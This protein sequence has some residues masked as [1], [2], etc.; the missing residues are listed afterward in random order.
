MRHSSRHSESGLDSSAHGSRL[1]AHGSPGFTLVGV[2]VA[3]AI[4]TI[5]VAAI[6]PS[7]YAISQREK[8]TE[9]IFRG[10]QYARAIVLFQRKFGRLPN[11]INEL[12]KS[13]PHTLRKRYKEPMCD[14][15]QWHL[16]IAGTPDASPPGAIPGLQGTP[17]P[18]RTPGSGNQ[19]PS[20]YT[21]LFS[22]TPPPGAGGAAPTP[23]FPS[24]F[25]TPGDQVVGPIVGVRSNVHKRG[26]KKW[27]DL[28]WYDEWRFIAGD[29]D[30][31]MPGGANPVLGGI[32]GP[33]PAPRR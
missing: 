21:G 30:N 26:F 24:L 3:I 2:V 12:E 32:R 27:R 14:C 13:K 28:E 33:T 5:L 11:S 16:I 9:L 22:T 17:R 29:A 18:N 7:V 25:G 8:E 15:D 10:R 4:L 31:E 20:T 1:T 23:G 6:G 19:P